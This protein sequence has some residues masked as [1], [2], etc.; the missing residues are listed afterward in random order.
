MGE[1]ARASEVALSTGE[2]EREDGRR[3]P[4]C[5]PQQLR[6]MR[7]LRR[8]KKRR[9]GSKEEGMGCRRKRRK[10][11]RQS[12]QDK[13]ATVERE[14]GARSRDRRRRRADDD[15]SPLAPSLPPL[16]PPS[17]RTSALSPSLPARGGR[18]RDFPGRAAVPSL[19]RS[20]LSLS[21]RAGRA[22]QSVSILHRCWED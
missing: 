5:H 4:P 8:H 10:R 17:R 9:G 18:E 12:C 22:R 15:P 6:D 19:P 2:G 13:V 11:R 7:S 14:R 3:R 21:A 1:G 20:L 16:R